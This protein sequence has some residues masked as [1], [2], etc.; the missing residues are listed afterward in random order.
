MRS[1]TAAQQVDDEEVAGAAAPSTASILDLNILLMEIRALTHRREDVNRMSKLWNN[2]TD[3]KSRLANM[4]SKFNFR[5]N[6]NSPQKHHSQ[7]AKEK[8]NHQCNWSPSSI[9]TRDLASHQWTAVCLGGNRKFN[10]WG[11]DRW[12]SKRGLNHRNSHSL[13]E[14]QQRKLLLYVR[15]LSREPAGRKPRASGERELHNSVNREFRF[16]NEMTQL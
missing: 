2:L 6:K 11:S 15:I 10:E 13:D 8:A 1:Q 9:G 16:H 7:E 14:M 12:K 3:R 4:I 5:K